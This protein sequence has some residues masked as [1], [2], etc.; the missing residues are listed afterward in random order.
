MSYK[1]LK[2]CGW[3]WDTWYISNVCRL[4]CWLCAVLLCDVCVPSVCVLS[5]C[6]FL[7]TCC[8]CE[9]CQCVGC[10][11][12]V[13]VLTFV[14]MFSVCC[15]LVCCPYSLL[16]VSCIVCC[17]YVVL[18]CV[19]SAPHVRVLSL[20]CPSVAFLL[21]FCLSTVCVMYVP[22]FT[23]VVRMQSISLFAVCCLSV[24]YLSSL[25]FL[26]CPF[27]VISVCWQ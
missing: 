26:S 19:G 9:I 25:N 7:F 23:C 27:R 12:S 15:S 1:D 16:F 21:M 14:P 13:H 20:R 2:H 10:L 5:L 6:S 24:Y 8:L 17:M 11:T 22:S 4:V 18:L 3:N